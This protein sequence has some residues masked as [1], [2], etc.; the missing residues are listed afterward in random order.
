[1]PQGH[2]WAWPV[3]APWPSAGADLWHR[4]FHLHQWMWELCL[5][6]VTPMERTCF[7]SDSSLAPGLS[8]CAFP[9]YPPCLPLHLL[10]VL[11]GKSWRFS[12][13][14]KIAEESIR[15][16]NSNDAAHSDGR[17]LLTDRFI[18]VRDSKTTSLL[19]V[20]SDELSFTCIMWEFHVHS[21]H[22]CPFGKMVTLSL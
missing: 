5:W 22:L 1:M 3:R 19:V 15:S 13:E 20:N 16:G 17:G 21:Q 11:G 8:P 18:I 10:F 14:K 4:W 9:I 7:L 6:S 12:R 2:G